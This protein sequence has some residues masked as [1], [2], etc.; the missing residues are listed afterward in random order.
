MTVPG[1]PNMFLMYGPNT[2]LGSGSI[3]SMLEPQ[4]AYLR[5]ALDLLA[6]TPAYLDVRPEVAQAFD[7]ETQARISDSV[8]THCDSWYRLP[9]GRV[10]TNWPGTVAEYQ[11]RTRHLNPGDFVVTRLESRDDQGEQLVPGRRE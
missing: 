4:A 11:K 1:F 10:P 5:Q 2:N 3:I 6:T 7:A 8:W 9:S